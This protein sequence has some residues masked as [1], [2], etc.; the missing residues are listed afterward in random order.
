[1]GAKLTEYYNYVDTMI[2]STDTLL[3]AYENKLSKLDSED[4]DLETDDW[5]TM[6]AKLQAMLNSLYVASAVHKFE[7]ISKTQMLRLFR[8]YEEGKGTGKVIIDIL[9]TVAEYDTPR[10]IEYKYNVLW[11]KIMEYNNITPGQLYP[12]LQIRIPVEVEISV[13]ASKEVPT[14]GDQTGN[15]ILGTDLPSELE[16]DS[17]GDL[18][19]LDEVSSFQQAVTNLLLLPKGS[20][21]YYEELGFDPD[22]SEEYN[23][24]EQDAILQLRIID[25]LNGDKRINGVSIQDSAKDGVTR[26]YSVAIEAITGEQ[27]IAEV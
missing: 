17:T 20:Q 15:K 13:I 10:S 16:S 21:P 14:F 19:V 6:I 1:M 9:H 18:K 26:K 4:Y 3:D 23:S 27:T 11:L 22:V 12:M 8:S 2:Y 24:E 7:R 25:A 5:N